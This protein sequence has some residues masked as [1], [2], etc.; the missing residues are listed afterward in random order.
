M[1]LKYST[2][3]RLGVNWDYAYSKI[4][5]NGSSL[6]KDESDNITTPLHE[7]INHQEESE[8]GGGFTWGDGRREW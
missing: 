1:K 7:G 4:L 3:E 6:K 5:N 8:S 2:Q